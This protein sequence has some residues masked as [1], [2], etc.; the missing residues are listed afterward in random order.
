MSMNDRSSSKAWNIKSEMKDILAGKS[1][2]E[3]KINRYREHYLDRFRETQNRFNMAEKEVGV[4]LY[5]YMMP[6]SQII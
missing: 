2:M 1:D 5:D 4:A 6:Q 3:S